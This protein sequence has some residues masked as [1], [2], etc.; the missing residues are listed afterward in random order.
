[1][2]LQTKRVEDARERA[3][4]VLVASLCAFDPKQSQKQYQVARQVKRK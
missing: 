1:M 4:D 3:N 2:A